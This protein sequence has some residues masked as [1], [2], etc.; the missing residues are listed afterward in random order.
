VDLGG[1]PSAYSLAQGSAEVKGLTLHP[2]AA[3]E[4]LRE[5]QRNAGQFV[6]REQYVTDRH[7]LARL[8][9]L[10]VATL[11]LWAAVLVLTLA[12]L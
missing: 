7:R 11:A 1:P 4:R 9:S 8:R 2:D 12:R 6:D 5:L 10:W 3:L